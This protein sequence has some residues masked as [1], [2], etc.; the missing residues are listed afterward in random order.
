MAAENAPC[1]TVTG[2]GNYSGTMIQPFTIH[3]KE[4]A[5]SSVTVQI[6]YDDSG[7]RLRVAAGKTELDETQYQKETLAI[8]KAG[9]S[10]RVGMDELALGEKYDIE[11]T[12]C[13]DYRVK[14]KPAKKTS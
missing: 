14:N 12:L 1:V 9:T 4:I 8:Y 11:I 3:P 10:T 13:G 2:I 6:A 7:S 5:E